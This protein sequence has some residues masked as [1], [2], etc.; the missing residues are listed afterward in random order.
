MLWVKQTTPT[1]SAKSQ[2]AGELGPKGRR[3]SSAATQL[4]VR[5]PANF[6]D[7]TGLEG[8]QQRA[9][10]TSPPSGLVVHKLPSDLLE[11][12]FSEPAAPAVAHPSK[13]SNL[14]SGQSPATG[15]VSLSTP[16]PGMASST[17][18]EQPD[19]LFAPDMPE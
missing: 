10:E 18:S 2:V 8:N 3:E 11:F 17:G 9:S 1:G 16:E 19:G 7:F 14:N 4:A 5:S 15:A 13:S 12:E 6:V